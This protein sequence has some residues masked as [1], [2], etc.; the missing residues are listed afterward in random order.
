MQNFF[1]SVLNIIKYFTPI[2]IQ[3][4]AKC[5]TC[6]DPFCLTLYLVL[7]KIQILDLVWDHYWSQTVGK[8]IFVKLLLSRLSFVSHALNNFPRIVLYLLASRFVLLLLLL[9][10]CCLL[11]LLRC[12]WYYSRSTTICICFRLNTHPTNIDF[13]MDL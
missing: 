2:S 11:N 5:R 1:T 9:C 6:R 10:C 4:L 7:K 3:N 13:F 12:R 8:V